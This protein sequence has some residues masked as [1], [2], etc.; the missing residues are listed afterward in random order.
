MD[1]KGK[2]VL[3]V[4]DST[5][6]LRYTAKILRDEGF[7]TSLAQDAQAALKLLEHLSPD[8]ILLDIIMPILI[9]ILV[10]SLTAMQAIR[11]VLW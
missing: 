2:H 3:I 7:R 5:N 9:T 1:A 11:W 4:D 10:F 8:I 6:N